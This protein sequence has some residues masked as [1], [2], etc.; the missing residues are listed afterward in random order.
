MLQHRDSFLNLRCVPNAVASGLAYPNDLSSLH[1]PT[2]LPLASLTGC[3]SPHT[4]RKG[5]FLP[6]DSSGT[7]S[8]ATGS[9]AAASGSATSI[10]TSSTDSSRDGS[11]DPSPAAA[12]RHSR[13]GSSRGSV[14]GVT[15]SPQKEH[16]KEKKRNAAPERVRSASPPK[17]EPTPPKAD[18]PPKSEPAPARADTPVKHDAEAQLARLPHPATDDIF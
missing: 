1:R 13:S 5:L 12:T 11:R 10:Q 3:S 7:V 6:Q 17:T 4:H 8:T 16:R 14:V 15:N 9:A 2:P 18:T